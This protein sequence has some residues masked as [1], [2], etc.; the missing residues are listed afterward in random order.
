MPPHHSLSLSPSPSL[1]PLSLSLSLCVGT[2]WCLSPNERVCVTANVINKFQWSVIIRAN[3]VNKNNDKRKEN[4]K[5]VVLAVRA[6]SGVPSFHTS[7]TVLTWC[8]S[9]SRLSFQLLRCGCLWLCALVWFSSLFSH[10]PHKYALI[11]RYDT[12]THTHSAS[13]HY[14]CLTLLPPAFLRLYTCDNTHRD[15]FAFS[16]ELFTLPPPS[17]SFFTL[18]FLFSPQADL[19]L[20]ELLERFQFFPHIYELSPFRHKGSA[21]FTL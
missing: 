3:A 13:S 20:C 17:F 4:D 19:I 16:R 12:H 8:S 2:M 21:L 5:H 7:G 6:M 14:P 10:I 18:F 15:T 9:A 11:P 1:S